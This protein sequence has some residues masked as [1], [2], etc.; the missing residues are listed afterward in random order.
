M[1]SG[2]QIPLKPGL[3]ASDFEHE[4]FGASQNPPR[5]NSQSSTNLQYCRSL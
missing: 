2:L 3:Q 4:Y 5:G 1:I